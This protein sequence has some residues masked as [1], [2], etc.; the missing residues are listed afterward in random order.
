M[1]DYL[2]AELKLTHSENSDYTSPEWQSNWDDYEPT[3]DE[4]RT[5][6]LEVDTSA[7]AL[8][9]TDFSTC[10]LMAIKNTDAA[11]FVDVTWDDTGGNSNTQRIPAGGLLVVSGVDPSVNPTLT[12]DTAACVCK[13]AFA[14]S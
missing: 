12:A 14:G 1:T 4:V 10:S 8:D 9:I 5:M 13:L 2:K 11:N 7:V 3:P 6:K